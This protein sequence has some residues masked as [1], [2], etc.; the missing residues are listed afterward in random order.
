M[1]PER[2]AF[3]GGSFLARDGPNRRAHTQRTGGPVS[4]EVDQGALAGPRPPG[5][6]PQGS[7]PPGRASGIGSR[8]LPS[9]E[10][11]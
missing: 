11:S 9:I 2:H 6:R 7:F 4:A 10:S 8:G 3:L 5:Q 1:R